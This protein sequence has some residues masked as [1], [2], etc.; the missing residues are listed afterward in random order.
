MKSKETV[1]KRLKTHGLVESENQATCLI[2]GR[3]I[4]ADS[5]KLWHTVA[6]DS[7]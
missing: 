1:E 5:V 3:L 7:I 4:F 2:V 6:G